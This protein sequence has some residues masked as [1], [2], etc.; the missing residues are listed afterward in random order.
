MH[1]RK[2]DD[3]LY[4]TELISDSH[5]RPMQLNRCFGDNDDNH[6]NCRNSRHDNHQAYI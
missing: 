2:N 5:F 3:T 4:L 6:R 1:T